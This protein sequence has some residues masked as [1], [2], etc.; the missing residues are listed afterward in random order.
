MPVVSWLFSA[1]AVGEPASL[2]GR[3][4]KNFQTAPATQMADGNRH[5]ALLFF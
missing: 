4:K 5:A 3:L 1:R 2:M